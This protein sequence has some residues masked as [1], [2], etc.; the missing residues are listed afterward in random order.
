[1]ARP[2]KD[3]IDYFPH[4]TNMSNDDRMELVEYKFKNDGYAIYNKILERVYLTNGK[5]VISTDEQ[6]QIYGDKWHVGKDKLKE[7]IEYFF[8][9]K[10][11]EGEN[12]ISNG[13][14]KRLKRI[15]LERKRKRNYQKNKGDT[16]GVMDGYN[17]STSGIIPPKEKESKE[18]ESKRNSIYKIV[19]P[20]LE[21]VRQY[22]TENNYKQS[23]AERFFNYYEDNGWVTGKA[24]MKMKDWSA[25]VRNWKE[26]AEGY[27]KT[28]ENP[29]EQKQLTEADYKRMNQED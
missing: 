1:M 23:E 15:S 24:K 7:I 28:I 3:E 25:G 16:K 8:E 18:K 12:F 20:T 9:I 17:P 4:N 11:F 22:F 10:L 21:Q 27:G 26:R 6:F 14:K 2:L 5:F 29:P 19:P 13:V